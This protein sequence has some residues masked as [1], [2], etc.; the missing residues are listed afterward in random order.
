MSL[1][2]HLISKFEQIIDHAIQVMGLLAEIADDIEDPALRA[3]ITSIIGDENGHVRFLTLLLSL[4]GNDNSLR[5]SGVCQCSKV[6]E[7]LH[8]EAI[9]IT[10]FLSADNPIVDIPVSMENPSH[11]Q[12]NDPD[13]KEKSINSPSFNHGDGP[14]KDQEKLLQKKPKTLVWTFGKTS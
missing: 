2:P 1:S 8:T 11:D 13:T 6:N 5:T 14:V 12:T 9:G 4:A 10:P 3:S 7:T